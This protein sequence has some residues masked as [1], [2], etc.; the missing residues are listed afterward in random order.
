MNQAASKCD[1]IPMSETDL[2]KRLSDLERRHEK[3]RGLLIDAVSLAVLGLIGFYFKPQGYAAIILGF[4]LGLS[5]PRLLSWLFL[6]EGR[7]IP[8]SRFDRASIA[9]RRYR[10]SNP[11]RCHYPLLSASDSPIRRVG[12]NYKFG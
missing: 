10:T 11:D 1:Q 9:A 8:I 3:T 4:C 7:L 5:V 2:E 12:F 6:R